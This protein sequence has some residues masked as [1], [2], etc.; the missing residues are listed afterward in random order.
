MKLWLIE[1][2]DDTDYD[3]THAILVRAANEDAAR[4]EALRQY[5]GSQGV[6]RPAYPG[7]RADNISIS[8]VTAEGEPGVIMTDFLNG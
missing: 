5:E 1:R 8:E 7:F 3:E 2:T 6:S 4:A